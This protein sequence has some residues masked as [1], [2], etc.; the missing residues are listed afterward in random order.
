MSDG[1]PQ[2]QFP[3]FVRKMLKK[4]PIMAGA[5]RAEY[6]ELV[7]IVWTDGAKKMSR[8]SYAEIRACWG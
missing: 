2:A 4:P 6:G 5:D 1:D 3:F 8:Y 7:R